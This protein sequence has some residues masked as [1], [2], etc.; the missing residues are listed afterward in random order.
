MII[1]VHAH[2][3]PDKI[4]ARAIESL[5]AKSG[6]Y[7]P[8]GDGTL[9]NLLANMNEAAIDLAF[10]ANIAT[11]PKQFKSIVDWSISIRSDKIFPLGSVHPES[12]DFEGEISCLLDNGFTGIKLHPLYQEFYVDDKKVLPFFKALEQSGMFVLMHAGNDIAFPGDD[13]ASPARMARLIERVPSLDII[14]A[15]MGGWE[16]RDAV[17][18]DLAGAPCWFDT[19]FIAHIDRD[20]ICRIVEKHGMYKIVFGSDFPWQRQKSQIDF[21]RAMFE[22]SEDCDKILSGNILDLLNKHG[23]S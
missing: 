18:S 1:D 8:F 10:A 9:D 7:K 5:A 4:A 13:H 14:A 19:S 16:V 23:V 17:L 3:F 15:H 20:L 22:K 11:S 2:I 12:N 6:D 21:I